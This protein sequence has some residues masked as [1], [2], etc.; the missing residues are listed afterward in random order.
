MTLTQEQIDRANALQWFHALEFGS[1]QTVGRFASTTPPNVTLFGVLDLLAGID[2]KGLRCLDV[3]PA[4][5]LISFGLALK[6]AQ[7]SAIDVVSPESPQINLAQEIYGVNI[8]RRS[9]VSLETSPTVFEPG[10]FDLIVCAGVMYHLLNPADTFFRLRPLLKRNGLLVMETAYAKDREDPVLVLNSETGTDKQPTTYFL[11]SGSAIRGLA[12]LACFDVLGTRESSPSRFAL[13]GRAVLPE[14]VKDRAEHC[15][16]MH[17]KGFED[18]L[19]RLAAL[20]SVPESTIGFHAEPGH[21]K[22]D[23]KTYIPD[24]PSHPKQIVNPVGIP[25]SGQ[26]VTYRKS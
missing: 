8:D 21:K 12:K 9:P 10:T 20:N 2:V 26:G 23:V 25:I 24:F 5:G 15:I 14:E 18:P 3:G 4:H 22:I 6:G 7:V 1:H 17:D 11:A 13:A 16:A 19:F